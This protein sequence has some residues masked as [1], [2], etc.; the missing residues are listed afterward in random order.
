MD[1]TIQKWE[2]RFDKGRFCS[3]KPSIPAI[4][5][6]QIGFQDGLKK[7]QMEKDLA[8]GPLGR[9]YGDGYRAG[10]E[11]AFDMTG[12]RRRKTKKR[13]RKTRRTKKLN[14]RK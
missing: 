8:S 7:R 11:Y 2:G 12:S 9:D 4:G 3:D 6:C 5:R 10:R 13:A 1:P 14:G